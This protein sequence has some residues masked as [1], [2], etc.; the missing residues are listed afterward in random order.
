MLAV[1]G[2]G[3][4]QVYLHRYVVSLLYYVRCNTPYLLNELSSSCYVSNSTEDLEPAVM[5]YE[6]NIVHYHLHS[7][8]VTQ[9]GIQTQDK[10]K[11]AV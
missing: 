6:R 10:R 2:S 4:S 7:A 3:L 1:Y 8:I 5:Q 11:Q 9:K